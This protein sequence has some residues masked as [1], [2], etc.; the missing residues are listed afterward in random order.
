[1]AIVVVI[2]VLSVLTL[3]RWRRRRH[4]DEPD[5][6]PGSDLVDD[7]SEEAG[8]EVVGEPTDSA[9]GDGTKTTAGRA[10]QNP[11]AED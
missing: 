2:L 11:D 3:V 9:D 4:R 8:A 7:G 6:S 10:D 5:P 1:V